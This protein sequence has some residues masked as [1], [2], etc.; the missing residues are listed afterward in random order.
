M[1]FN[2][3]EGDISKYISKF[4]ENGLNMMVG[5]ARGVAWV[6]REVKRVERYLGGEFHRIL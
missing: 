2:L 4:V 1:G 3:G 5:L 6:R